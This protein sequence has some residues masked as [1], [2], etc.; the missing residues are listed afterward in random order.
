M[1][2]HQ[3]SQAVYEKRI[4]T[5]NMNYHVIFHIILQTSLSPQM[6]LIFYT[7]Y[8]IETFTF[9]PVNPISVGV[10]SLPRPISR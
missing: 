1:K 6:N 4:E 7:F 8:N 2:L 3:I 10:M 9:D 5:V